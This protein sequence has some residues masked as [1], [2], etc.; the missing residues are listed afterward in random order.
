MAA[1]PCCT[2]ETRR[3]GMQ[4]RRSVISLAA[5]ARDVRQSNAKNKLR[6]QLVGGGLLQRDE[7]SRRSP[8]ARARSRRCRAASSPWSPRICGGDADAGCERR[9]WGR[10]TT[11]IRL[12][13]LPPFV[14][15]SA[16][17]WTRSVVPTGGRTFS[18]SVKPLSPRRQDPPSPLATIFSIPFGKGRCSFSASTVSPSSQRPNSSVVVRITGMALG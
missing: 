13:R 10:S 5:L 2:D 17:V 12:G 18:S 14:G 15:H 7:N 4:A 8:S 11:A 1:F 9:R 16:S 3:P 6:A